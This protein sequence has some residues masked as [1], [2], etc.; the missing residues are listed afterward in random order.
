MLH[1]RLPASS[2]PTFG[3]AAAVICAVTIGDDLAQL[4]QAASWI[5][6]Q[7]LTVAGGGVQELD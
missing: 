2:T 6:G 4:V 7:I 1:T 5:R 3:K